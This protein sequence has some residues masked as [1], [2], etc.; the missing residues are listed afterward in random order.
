MVKEWVQAGVLGDVREVHIWTNRPIW[1]QNLD[2][3]KEEQPVPETLDW[4]QWL[5]VAPLRPYNEC[6]VP[7]KWRGWWDFGCGAIGDM[8]CHTMDAAFWGLDLSAPISVEAEV[9]GGNEETAPAGSIITYQFGA[10]GSMPPVTLKWYDGTKTPPRPKELESDR[11][12][13]KSGQLWF[14]DKAVLM[15]T[16]DYCNSPRLIPEAR[17]KDFKRVPKTFRRVPGAD[18][19]QEW[20]TACKGGPMCGSNFDYAGLLTETA[21]LGNVAVRSGKKFYWDGMNRWQINVPNCPDV[22]RYLRKTYRKY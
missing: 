8:A 13:A 2:R 11:K 10:R 21:L 15:D 19:Y 22:N 1:P 9:D 18:P 20:I 16:T 3:P 17:M 4:N 7:F 6:Y 12:M 5:G 14:G